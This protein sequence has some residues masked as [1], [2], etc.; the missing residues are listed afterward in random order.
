MY[1][2]THTHRL[3]CRGVLD[4]GASFLRGF[5][6]PRLFQEASDSSHELGMMFSN[7]KGAS[8]HQDGGMLLVHESWN[9]VSV[10]SFCPY[11]QGTPRAPPTPGYISYYVN[12]ERAS[13]SG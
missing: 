10:K 2:H 4:K 7:H 8:P 12:S 5:L 13:I 3:M 6:E 1:V 9:R 11:S